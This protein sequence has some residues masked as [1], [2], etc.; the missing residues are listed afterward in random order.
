MMGTFDRH[1]AWEFLR[2]L[3]VSLGAFIVIFLLVDILDNIDTYIDRRAPLKAVVMYYVYLCPYIIVLTL[4]VA[5]LLASLLSVGSMARSNE[6]VAM[7]TSG[8]SLYRLLAPLWGIG[9]ALS[10]LVGFLGGWIYPETNARMER[11]KRHEIERRRTRGSEPKRNLVHQDEAGRIYHVN[12]L[13]AD[14]GDAEGISIISGSDGTVDWRIDAQRGRYVNG[15]WNLGSGLLRVFSG[16][17]EHVAP[18]RFLRSANLSVPP[19]DLLGKPQEPEEIGV[20]DL[21]RLI[22]R[23]QRSGLSTAKQ[24]VELNLRFSFP[25][26][27]FLM[28][29]LG[30]PLASNPRR[31]GLALSFGLSIAISFA[32]FGTVRAC[33][34]LGHH[35]TLPPAVAAWIPDILF[36]VAGAWIL[37]KVRK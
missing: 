10:I 17:V 25:L 16:H 13:R 34:A 9:L 12:M 21:K 8:V 22:R 11:I 29:L 33:Q 4:P 15:L 27:N 24:E 1:V 28:V 3:S 6:L 23:M 14:R 7:K 30:A 32:F 37:I 5:T 19:I 31:S 36:L 18:F 2:I 26:A 35:E 20:S